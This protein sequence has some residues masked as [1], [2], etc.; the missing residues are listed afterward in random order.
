[1]TYKIRDWKGE[2]IQGSFYAEELQKIQE[3]KVYKVERILDRKRVRGRAMVLVKWLGYS[4]DFN[5][6][7]PESDID[8][9]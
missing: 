7:I 3:P 9:D 8:G 5:Q 4:D 1:M 6:W 2:E